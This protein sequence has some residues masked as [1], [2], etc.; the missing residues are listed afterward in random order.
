MKTNGEFRFKGEIQTQSYLLFQFT[1]SSNLDTFIRVCH[2]VA[3][4]LSDV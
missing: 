1:T 3:L 2:N 4:I